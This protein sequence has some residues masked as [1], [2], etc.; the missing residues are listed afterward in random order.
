M[1]A[2]RSQPAEEPAAPS[3]A[4]EIREHDETGEPA[5]SGKAGDTGED[6]VK[7][8][9]REALERKQTRQAEAN[10]ANRER[11]TAKIGS[12]HGPARNRRSFRRKSG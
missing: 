1:A 12:P 2:A 6:D 5:E 10:A 11:G 3:P 9:F 4:A 8:R 7:R